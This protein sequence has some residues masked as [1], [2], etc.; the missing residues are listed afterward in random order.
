MDPMHG[1][2]EV[3]GLENVGL[4]L[5]D[6]YEV[7]LRQALS[8]P[9]VTGRLNLDSPPRVFFQFFN[10]VLT[11]CG[12]LDDIEAVSMFDVSPA[13]EDFSRVFGDFGGQ[14]A[15]LYFFFLSAFYIELLSFEDGGLNDFV[16]FEFFGA[17]FEFEALKCWLLEPGYAFSIVEDSG[18]AVLV[19]DV[20]GVHS[21]R[22][23]AHAVAG[24]KVILL[25]L[26]VHIRR[27]GT[28]L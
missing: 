27:L 10:E 8:D 18:D 21:V 12:V 26:Q 14:V 22:V 1:D 11:L 20:E 7:A 17:A 2:L 19:I 28:L 5:E 16:D 15:E 4:G 3:E 9:P 6:V 25:L 23:V 13:G 24:Q